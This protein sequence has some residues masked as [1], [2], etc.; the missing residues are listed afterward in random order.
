MK[1]VSEKASNRIDPS[2]IKS[3][4]LTEDSAKLANDI[5]SGMKLKGDAVRSLTRS[6]GNNRKGTIILYLPESVRSDV[7]KIFDLSKEPS[8]FIIQCKSGKDTNDNLV[9]LV[10]LGFASGGN[11][12]DSIDD[13]VIEEPRDGKEI[14]TILRSKKLAFALRQL[15][16][17]VRDIRGHQ[18]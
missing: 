4:S 17:V 3:R 2:I 18:K 13:W 5:L 15:E 7:R 16:E 6:G 1:R 11:V 14:E 12:I 8:E 9:T 10:T